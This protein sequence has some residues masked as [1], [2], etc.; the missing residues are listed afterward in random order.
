M[1]FRAKL[2]FMLLA[3]AIAAGGVARG[4]IAIVGPDQVDA[5]DEVVC[6][7]TGTPAID[8]S[9][10]LVEQL[11]WLSGERRMVAYLAAPGQGLA[12]LSVRAE[13]VFGAQ[14]AT[15][16]PLVRFT[17]EASGVYGA[18]VVRSTIIPA[19]LRR[20]AMALAA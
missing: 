20:F 12:P 18:F 11:G 7:L 6:R 4:E 3:A 9:T 13:L 16:E 1:D 14:G 8:L 17:P 2:L 10:P 15:L 5:G 19:E